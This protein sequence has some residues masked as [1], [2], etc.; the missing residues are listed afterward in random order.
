MRESK[1]KFLNKEAYQAYFNTTNLE[2]TETTHGKLPKF[3]DG[4]E[5]SPSP[6]KCADS[7]Q[8]QRA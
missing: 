5:T 3:S 8:F 7:T 4:A 6:E 1:G 2:D